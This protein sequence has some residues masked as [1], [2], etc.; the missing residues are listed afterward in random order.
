MAHSGKPC[1]SYRRS[2]EALDEHAQKSLH[3]F[4]HHHFSPRGWRAVDASRLRSVLRLTLMRAQ[5]ILRMARGVRPTST[6]AAWIA[7]ATSFAVVVSSNGNGNRAAR[8]N[9][10]TEL[11]KNLVVV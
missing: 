4:S 6:S 2:Q 7:M 9:M 8:A 5:P 10:T 3:V 11:P 1:Q